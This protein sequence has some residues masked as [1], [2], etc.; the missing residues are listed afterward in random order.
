MQTKH[1][2]P[3][4]EEIIAVETNKEEIIAVETIFIH[5]FVVSCDGHVLVTSQ[6]GKLI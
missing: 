5:H 1:Y 6:E 3:N 2:F 4:K